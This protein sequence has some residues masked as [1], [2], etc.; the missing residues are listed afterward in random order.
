MSNIAS[1]K[2]IFSYPGFWRGYKFTVEIWD[3]EAGEVVEKPALSSN[4]ELSPDGAE[5]AEPLVIT[6][7]YC[8]DTLS[9]DVSEYDLAVYLDA[10]KIPTDIN[11]ISKTAT[12]DVW[13]FTDACVND[14]EEQTFQTQMPVTFQDWNFGWRF[15]SDERPSYTAY[16]PATDLNVLNDQNGNVAVRA[17]ADG[18]VVANS[19]DWGGIVIEHTIGEKKYYSQY[20]HIKHLTDDFDLKGSSE[21][22]TVTR[23]QTIGYIG[24]KKP[25]GGY[26]V[27]KQ[28]NPTGFHLHFEIRNSFHPDAD[29][30]DYWKTSFLILLWQ[31]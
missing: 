28:G 8:P 23:G 16:H 13:H 6:I 25:G 18:K 3:E 29:N 26:Y 17:I 31:P 21:E 20:G 2:K 12:A 15:M 24:N 9:P 27:D 14:E 11:T 30:A 4:Y 10:E 1:I 22:L 7:P 5:F 19:S